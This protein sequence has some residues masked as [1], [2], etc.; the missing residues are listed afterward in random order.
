MM[1]EKKISE[2]KCNHAWKILKRLSKKKILFSSDMMERNEEFY[3]LLQ[4]VE[5]IMV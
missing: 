2:I 5:F 3:S 4:A 1:E